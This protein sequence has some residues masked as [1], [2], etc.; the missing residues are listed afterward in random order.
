[1]ATLV[2]TPSMSMPTNIGIFLEVA[3]AST[4]WALPHHVVV[5][6]LRRRYLLL[7]PLINPLHVLLLYSVSY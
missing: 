1:M 7:S 2:A 3:S 5:V 6:A 4:A